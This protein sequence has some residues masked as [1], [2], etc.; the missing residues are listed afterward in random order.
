MVGADGDADVAAGGEELAGA[1]GSEIDVL[2]VHGAAE[3]GVVRGA[4]L[5]ALEI[6]DA[7]LGLVA[8][9]VIV[10]VE[11]NGERQTAAG[12]PKGAREG[13]RERIK[14]TF[15]LFITSRSWM[16]MSQP[17]R[18]VAKPALPSEFL[19]P[20]SYLSL[21]SMPPRAAYCGVGVPLMMAWVLP[22]KVKQP[23][24]QRQTGLVWHASAL[25]AESLLTLPEPRLT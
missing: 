9:E 14:P 22:P 23:K 5:R 25:T 21:T 11:P 8:V 2:A 13:R 18:L 1:V 3:G 12:C 6:D 20:H 10:A 4:G 17:G 19:P 7:V 24:R 15:T 16:G